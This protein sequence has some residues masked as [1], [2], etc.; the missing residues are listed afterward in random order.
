MCGV[1]GAINFKRELD[2]KTTNIEA[3]TQAVHH[4]GPDAI[5]YY[6]SPNK[7][8]IFGHN[9]LCITGVTNQPTI[10]ALNKKGT[11]SQIA[12]VFNG[13]IY[14]FRELKE[15][16]IVKG[17][18]F[19]S[20]SDFE[21]IVHGWH[22]WGKKCVDRL[23]GEFAFVVYNEETNQVL[24]GRD[25]TGVKPMF[26]SFAANGDF[27]FGSEPKAVLQHPNVKKV[28]DKHALAEFILEAHTFAGGIHDPGS[29]FYKNVKQLKAGFFATLDEVRGFRIKRYWDITFPTMPDN[30]NHVAAVRKAVKESVELRVPTEVPTSIGLSGGVDSSIVA[31]VAKN[32]P[33]TKD[34]LASC[35]QY[36][37]ADNE[38]YEHAKIVS[39][40]LSITL[41]SPNLTPEKMMEYIDRCVIAMDGPFDSIRRIGMLANYETLA[42]KGYKV[43]LIGEGSDEFN[44]GYYHTFPGLKLDQDKCR[45]SE[46]LKNLYGSRADFV[47]KFFN[48][49]FLSRVNYKGIIDHVVE[50]YYE[51]CAESD[52]L[53][54]MQYFY[55]KRFLQFLEDSNDRV[56]AANAIEARLPFVSPAVI[57]ACLAM[58][59]EKNVTKESEKRILREAF[60]DLL[61][62]E[63]YDRPKSPFPANEN[64]KL[65]KMIQRLFEKNISQAHQSIWQML[66][67]DE[68]QKLNDGYYRSIQRLEKS[69]KGGQKLNTWIPVSKSIEVR[70]YHVFTFLTLLRWYKL[71]F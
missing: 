69:G 61:P 46:D 45:S 31:A 40:K 42:Q 5:A 56:A 66:N 49:N 44:L 57:E 21:V 47:V 48:A 38:D 8:V 37:D 18:K 59:K 17:Y 34:I 50:E 14:N 62:A 6:H 71:N 67:K 58:P 25:S 27:V 55:A 52:P 19:I 28:I 54:K 64:L 2:S 60:R 16:L 4:R 23:D 51:H 43:T 1:A 32:S 68:Q 53:K 7:H 3:M 39:E 70:T 10:M 22:E 30:Y 15:E 36:A 26:Y 33:Q 24:I 41:V 20:P 35:V 9:R 63:V 12:I 65:H 29:S 13:E 11:K